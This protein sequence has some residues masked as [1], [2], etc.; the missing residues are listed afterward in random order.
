[1]NKKKDR[2]PRDF[3]NNFKSLPVKLRI[4]LL[5]NARKLLKVQKEGKELVKS[6]GEAGLENN[7]ENPIVD[8]VVN[9][10]VERGLV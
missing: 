6:A 5:L 7:G 4:K 3:G 10:R 8:G 1:M 2:L 9:R